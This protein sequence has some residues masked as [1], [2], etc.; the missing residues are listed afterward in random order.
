MEWSVV[1]PVKDEIGYLHYSLPSIAKLHPSEIVLCLDYGKG[2]DAPLTLEEVKKNNLLGEIERYSV[3]V[4]KEYDVPLVVVHV[5]P[6]HSWRFFQAYVRRVGYLTASYDHIFTFDV[7]TIVT[8]EILKG[9]D[10]VGKNGVTFVTFR[11]KLNSQG[12]VQLFRSFLYDFRRNIPMRKTIA[13]M[14]TR[15]PTEPP[16][17][18]IITL[19]TNREAPIIP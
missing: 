10:L 5:K 13:S 15:M 3:V 4:C 18:A 1:L 12:L 14:V 19:L 17:N 9:F 8:S 2:H 16:G 11:K 7:D 6:K